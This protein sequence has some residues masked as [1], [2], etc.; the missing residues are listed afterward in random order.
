MSKN[1][2]KIIFKYILLL[3]VFYL[4]S[5]A[6][7][8]NELRIFSLG[9]AG[10]LI[11]LMPDN[12]FVAGLFVLAEFLAT[13][14]IVVLFS[15]AAFAGMLLVGK[16]I[17]DKLRLKRN[18]ALCSFYF[19]AACLPKLFF[20]FGANKIPSG[21]IFCLISCGVFI[22]SFVFIT[23]F[24]QRKAYLKLNLDEIACGL[25]IVIGCFCGLAQL[26][27]PY[28]DFVRF[29]ACLL[30]L[31]SCYCELYSLT[32]SLGAVF[33][34][35]VCLAGAGVEYIAMF[36]VMALMIKLF[37]S[38]VRLFSA[39][40][41][42][43]IDVI[44]GLYFDVFDG[45]FIYNVVATICAGGVFM[46]LPKKLFD[47]IIVNF[48][49][50]SSKM[51]Y[52]NLL[53]QSNSDI[54]NKLLELSEVFFDMDVGFRKLVKG[55]LSLE[56]SKKLFVKELC[57]SCCVSCE[58]YIECHR[59]NQKD[60]SKVFKTLADNGFEKGKITLLELPA[61]L[62]TNCNR[63]NVLLP[64]INGL[65]NQF[66]KASELEALEDSSKI[67]VADQ[68]RG[69]SKLLYELSQVACEKLVFD[70]K[71]EIEII[72]ELTYSD[73]ICSEASVYEKNKDN[74]RI[75][76]VV[77]KNDLQNEK[78]LPAIEKVCKQKLLVTDTCPALIS[79]MVVM[80]LESAP[81][82][83]IIFGVARA[84]KD[85]GDSCGDNYSLL[86]LGG[87]RFLLAICD[88][89]GSG[90][91]AGDMSQKAM[92]LIENFYR[93]QFDSEIILSS[94]NRLLSLRA[95]DTFSTIDVCLI[96]MATSLVDFVK[97]GACESYIKHSDTITKIESGALPVGVLD[98]VSPKIT[99]T[100]LTFGDMVVLVSDGI[101]D[102][103]GENELQSFILTDGSL[104]PQELADNILNKAKSMCLGIPCDDMTVVVGKIFKNS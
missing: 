89:M 13:F 58:N 73:I 95:T 37:K 20:I 57:D 91:V 11:L 25:V 46:L 27:I 33:G 49:H 93:A 39:L 31:I 66:K 92:E 17:N 98:K 102:S 61:Y 84:C 52:R 7:I 53:N 3:G 65:I 99:K 32:L 12:L 97:L 100:S 74:Y 63:I 6:Y 80:S 103:M 90:E 19:L 76:V 48:A 101:V 23:A 85:N 4:L 44:F 67:L 87:N 59:N 55:G 16:L 8:K 82:Y 47:Y 83:D 26:N 28:I 30:L 45:Y 1:L 18:V 22:A 41:C 104:S 2:I 72:E 34:I 10:S 70:N 42:V 38:D 54:A 68:L 51:A 79:G 86:R 94:V 71:K 43:S 9:F 15:S 69:L 14:D 29:F 21:I 88:G 62:T 24:L 56:E 35:G 5:I 60:M 78:L 64:T 50:P 75:G 81:K 96:D 77:R 36:A 40:A